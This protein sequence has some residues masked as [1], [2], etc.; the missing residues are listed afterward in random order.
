M[1]R[2]D[3]NEFGAQ[4]WQVCRIEKESYE[5]YRGSQHYSTSEGKKI[6]KSHQFKFKQIF[7]KNALTWKKVLGSTKYDLKLERAAKVIWNHFESHQSKNK[8]N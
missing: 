4:R 6:V 7:S 8:P 2:Q 1:K 3:L 5:E